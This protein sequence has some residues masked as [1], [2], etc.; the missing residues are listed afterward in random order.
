MP[1]DLMKNKNILLKNYVLQ[2]NFVSFF[3]IK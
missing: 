1:L 2:L 3:L